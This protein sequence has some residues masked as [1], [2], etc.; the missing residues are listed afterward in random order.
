MDRDDDDEAG[1]EA[2]GSSPTDR[3]MPFFAFAALSVDDT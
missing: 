3:S 2:V 1:A